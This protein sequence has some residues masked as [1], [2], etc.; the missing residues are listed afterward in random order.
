MLQTSSPL[1]TFSYLPPLSY[2]FYSTIVPILHS[3]LMFIIIITILDPHSTYE[4][5][6]DLFGFL[7]LVY[8][9]RNDNLMF[10][11]LCY[12]WHNF[13]FLHGWILLYCIFSLSVGRFL[14]TYGY[15]TPC[16]LHTVQQ[17][18]SN[19]CLRQYML[20]K[21]TFLKQHHFNRSIIKHFF[22]WSKRLT[23]LQQ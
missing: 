3:C 5:N 12:K 20:R 1:H 19:F 2:W 18:N 7:C 16:L 14:D 11:L 9:T 4:L 21:A 23:F 6:H 13:V 10:Q 17:W 15:S 8:F 22:L